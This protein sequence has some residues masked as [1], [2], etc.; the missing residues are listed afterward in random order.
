MALVTY[1][2]LTLFGAT[3][4]YSPGAK[5]YIYAAGTT[6]AVS[7]YSD[8]SLT[9]PAANPVVADGYG[10]MPVRHVAGGEYK[11]TLTTAGG[12]ILSSDDNVPIGTSDE[13]IA[14]AVFPYDA[15]EGE[16]PAT[17]TDYRFPLINVKR[18]GALGNGVANDTSAFSQAIAVAAE[19]GGTVYVPQSLNAYVVTS[20]ITLLDNVTI[21]G[22][23]YGSRITLASANTTLFSM[24]AKTRARLQ[25]LRLSCSAP[26]ALAEHAAVNMSGS[27]DC[28]VSGCFFDGWSGWCVNVGNA[29]TLTTGFI[30]SRNRFSGWS[31]P[32]QGSAA[33][34]G[35]YNCSNGE[36][37]GNV[38]NGGSSSSSTGAYFGIGFLE[39]GATSSEYFRDI[40]IVNNTV[41]AVREYGIVVYANNAVI[42][43]L[44]VSGNTVKTVYGSTLNTS[45]GAGIYLLRVGNATV[46]GNVVSA[47]N[48]ATANETLSPGAIGINSATGRITVTGNTLSNGAYH[49]INIESGEAASSVVVVGNTVD[50]FDKIGIY[51]NA[52][53]QATISGNSIR[54]S[55][56]T[57]G[58]G[59]LLIVGTVGTHVKHVA[60]SGNHII[61]AGSQQVQITYADDLSFT[62]NAVD[63]ND[64]AGDA[65]QF[66]SCDR[67][68]VAGNAIN[69]AATSGACLALSAVT[70]GR[71][72]GNVLLAGHSDDFVTTSGTCTG[73]FIDESN[74]LA[75]AGNAGTGSN[76]V[77]RATAAPGA[78]TYQ[79]GDRTWDTDVAAGAAPGWI[80]AG[81]AWK[82]MASIAA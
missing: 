5:L 39:S 58:I 6:T 42:D 48:L 25:N 70:A 65:V 49:G 3:G 38:I 82:A 19:C 63:M 45:A 72:S 23:G 11:L 12:S 8:A 73:T 59:A 40:R 4:R 61:A 29:A 31:S 71:V 74:G 33:I 7:V 30:V 66:A 37:S 55:A 22:D 79:V 1:P 21:R 53:G 46:S 17:P 18:Y 60:V 77:L 26:S 57:A 51:L 68:S 43:G 64:T 80:Y 27:T 9:T 14:Q 10:R 44:V 62:G 75:R 34:N 81:G 56:D 76:V 47:T 54:T 32:V 28:E 78:G 20:A 35:Y 24:T 52:Q 16:V 13:D 36:V 50:D 67:V 69:S 41:Q 15:I 2:R